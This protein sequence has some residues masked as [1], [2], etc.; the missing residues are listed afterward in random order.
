MAVTSMPAI[1]S[2]SVFL[3]ARIG[4]RTGTVMSRDA[5]SGSGSMVVMTTGSLRSNESRVMSSSRS[6]CSTNLRNAGLPMT[7]TRSM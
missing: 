5:F 4:L 1:S 3:R 6:N 7:S 2:A